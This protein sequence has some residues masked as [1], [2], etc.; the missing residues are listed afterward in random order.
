M[1][2]TNPH[3]LSGRAAEAG[4]FGAMALLP[5]V[6]TLVAVLR[7]ERPAFGTDAARQASADLAG[8]LRVVLTA[9]S[10]AAVDSADALLRTSSR[11]LLGVGTLVAVLALGRSGLTVI[12][13]VPARR[14]GREWVRAVLLE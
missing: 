7:A 3:D 1:R 13:G 9:R 10:T 5:S 8:L 14:A 6:L 4:F 11:G 12:S 2:A